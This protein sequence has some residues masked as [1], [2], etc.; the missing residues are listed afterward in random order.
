MPWLALLFAAEM[1]TVLT[2]T[3]FQGSLDVA[4]FALIV[5]FMP[6]INATAGNAGSQMAGLVIRGLAVHEMRPADWVRVLGRE[7]LL[8]GTM[9]L[10]LGLMGVAASMVLL[11]FGHTDPAAA[12]PLGHALGVSF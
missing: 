12:G 5:L 9:A 4:V 11:K 7:L 6:L 1:V 10:A 3:G 2:L 8:G